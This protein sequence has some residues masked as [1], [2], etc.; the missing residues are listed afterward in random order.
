MILRGWG[1]YTKIWEMY[2]ICLRRHL[3]VCTS[4]SAA[5]DVCCFCLI[6][7]MGCHNVTSC[8]PSGGLM[9]TAFRDILPQAAEA[10]HLALEIAF[11]QTSKSLAQT[12]KFL[13]VCRYSFV[14]AV[15]CRRR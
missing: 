9:S 12:L 8:L 6:K 15:P 14:Y 7:A 2:S 4:V 3:K 10:P 1:P 11:R 5:Y 13:D